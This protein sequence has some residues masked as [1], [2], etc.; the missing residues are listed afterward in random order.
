MEV[1][2][3]YIGGKSEGKGAG[4]YRQNKTI[5]I[6]MREHNGDVI[7]RVVA[8]RKRA[9]LEPH[10]FANVKPHSEIH[11][12]ELISYSDLGEFKGY[13]HKT[14]NHSNGEYVSKAGVS[15]NGVEGFWSQLK[16]ARRCFR[17]C[18]RLL[19]HCLQ[20]PIDLIGVALG[21][22]VVFF[23]ELVELSL[24]SSLLKCRHGFLGVGLPAFAKTKNT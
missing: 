21:V 15:T 20:S 5:V 1:D 10:V 11:T 18:F 12:D 2:E 22:S 8:D 17:N 6:G 13:W 24:L 4:N 19:G 9:T 16:R 7:T 3:T 23:D 14:V